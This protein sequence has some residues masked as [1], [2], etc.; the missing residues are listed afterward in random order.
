[1]ILMYILNFDFVKDVQN[2]FENLDLRVI[3]DGF[4]DIL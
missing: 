1:M 2:I 4:F 3:F